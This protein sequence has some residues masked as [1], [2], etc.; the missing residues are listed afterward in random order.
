MW[1]LFWQVLIMGTLVALLLIGEH[2]I[3]GKVSNGWVVGFSAGIG[4]VVGDAFASGLGKSDP[5]DGAENK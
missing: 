1:R 5:W 3:T 2:I 4:Y